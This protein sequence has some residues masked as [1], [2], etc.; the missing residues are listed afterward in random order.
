[1]KWL[2]FCLPPARPCQ[3]HW[4]WAVLWPYCCRAGNGVS[5]CAGLVTSP[6]V[7]A[8]PPTCLP[9]GLLLFFNKYITYSIFF[10]IR[11]T[12]NIEL[13]SIKSIAE[14]IKFNYF[15]PQRYILFTFHYISFSIFANVHTLKEL[16]SCWNSHLFVIVF[17]N[18]I[19]SFSCMLECDSYS[20]V[21]LC[22][23]NV[24]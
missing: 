3:C 7:C 18:T 21:L 13:T 6:A 16:R 8:Y 19:M 2:L 12:I 14:I 1:M 4:S 15:T 22:C 23:V 17:T 9:P 24:P 11:K 10:V 20:F 5:A